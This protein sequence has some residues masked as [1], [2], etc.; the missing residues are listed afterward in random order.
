L[1]RVS[2]AISGFFFC[3]I[4]LEPVEKASL[5]STKP[6]SC[7]FQVIKSSLNRERCISIIARQKRNSQTKSRSLTASTLF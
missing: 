5:N 6:N 7:V 4:K 3:G 2:S 1:P